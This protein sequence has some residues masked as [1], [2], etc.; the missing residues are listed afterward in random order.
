[1]PAGASASHGGAGSSRLSAR[2]ILGIL[3]DAEPSV[4]I[5]DPLAAPLGAGVEGQAFDG[6]FLV[7]DGSYLTWR[8]AAPAEDPGGIADPTGPPSSAARAAP[9][10]PLK[11]SN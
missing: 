3:A 2:E 8:D 10:V 4:L 5:V 9:P 6:R 11:A 1:V 7:T